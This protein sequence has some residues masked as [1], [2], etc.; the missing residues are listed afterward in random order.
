MKILLLI[1]IRFYW[2]LI[3]KG[4][5]PKCIYKES[6]S[7]HVYHITKTNG[8]SA[9]LKAFKLRYKNCRPG[10][11]INNSSSIKFLITRTGEKIEWEEVSDLFK[12]RIR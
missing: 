6:C 4:F 3:P 10:Y 1:I 11:S 5:R 12:Q 8:L 9:G 7:N 2:L